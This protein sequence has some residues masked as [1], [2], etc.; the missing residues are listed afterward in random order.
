MPAAAASGTKNTPAG[1]AAMSFRIT[2]TMAAALAQKTIADP[3]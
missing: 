1:S 3:S 2:P